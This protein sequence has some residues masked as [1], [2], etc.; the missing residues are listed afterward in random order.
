MPKHEAA[1]WFEKA[2]AETRKLSLHSDMQ[3]LRHS[4]DRHDAETRAL[5]VSSQGRHSQRGAI[6]VAKQPV[7]CD[8]E[9]ASAAMR[10]SCYTSRNSNALSAPVLASG[11]M[12]IGRPM[13]I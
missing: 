10:R 11:C 4:R 13:L 9:T 7:N 6:H 5:T 2:D 8:T 3:M 12:R 1:T